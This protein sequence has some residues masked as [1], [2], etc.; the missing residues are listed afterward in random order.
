MLTGA[1]VSTRNRK[2]KF[3]FTCHRPGGEIETNTTK[4]VDA[5]VELI[6]QQFWDTEDDHDV[7]EPFTVT[8]VGKHNTEGTNYNFVEY[9]PNREMENPDFEPNFSRVMEVRKWFDRTPPFPTDP[10]PT[11]PK[12]V[13]DEPED[14]V[15]ERQS[16]LFAPGGL[17]ELQCAGSGMAETGDTASALRTK[18]SQIN[19][20]TPPPR[21]PDHVVIDMLRD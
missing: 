18:I 5:G 20:H 14:F 19:V 3:F 15:Q 13:H 4:P 7:P 17:D 9:K 10:S 12:P 1:R 16:P 8:G 6:G 21:I 2:Q 11:L